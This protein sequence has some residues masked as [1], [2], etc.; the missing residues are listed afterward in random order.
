MAKNN[1]LK[2]FMTMIDD[3]GYVIVNGAVVS[4]EVSDDY[5]FAPSIFKN[6]EVLVP[7]LCKLAVGIMNNEPTISYRIPYNGRMKIVQQYIKEIV[8][9]FLEN[10][11]KRELV[12]NWTLEDD[13]RFKVVVAEDE[14]KRR[15]FRSKWAELVF[16][17]VIMKTVSMFCEN[18]K[19]SHKA[20]NN[21]ELKRKGET[22]LFTELD[23]VIQMQKRFYIFEVK[24]GPKINIMQWAKRENAFVDDNSLVRNI[25]CT[26]YDSIPAEIFEPQLLLNL[27][28]IEAELLKILGED[29]PEENKTNFADETEKV[30]P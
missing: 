29:F 25:V 26:V 20:F 9:Q 24:S 5:S 6:R 19:I 10:L 18:H 28:N 4:Q 27:G 17:H 30:Q 21:V 15:F 23:L 12:L 7:F 2:D 1:L 22:G 11:K 8:Q 3:R 16:R 13:V 14:Q